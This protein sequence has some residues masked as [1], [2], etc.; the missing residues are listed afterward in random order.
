MAMDTKEI[1]EL[2]KRHTVFSWAAQGNLNPIAVDR[3]EGIYFW[4]N[5]GKRYIDFNSQLM[6]VNIGHNHPK[7]VAAIKAQADKLFFSWPGSAT[8]PRAKLGKLLSEVVPGDINKFFFT[9]GG[10]EC[11][12][13]AIKVA[14]L[15]TGRHKII[16]RYRSYHGGTH[17]A[18]QLTGDPRRW[19]T[20]PGAP[21]F[22]KVMDPAPYR[23]SFGSTDEERTRNNLAYLAEVIDYEGP[24]NIAAMF[25]EPV[26]G[27]NGI[28]APPA[29]YL[30]GLRALLDE[31]GILLVC[32]E[33]M[34]GWGRTGKLFSHEHAGITPDI[35]CMAKGL[36]SAALP[37]GAM[38]MRDKIAAYFDDNVFWAGLTYS[39]HA[40]GIAAAIAAIEVMRDEGLVE[41]AAKMQNVMRKHMTE[42]KEKHPSVATFRATGLFG[43]IDFRK[44][45]VGDPL[46]GYN[47][48]HPAVAKLVKAL[49][50]KGL[51]T[52][53]HWNYIFCNP[54][55]CISEEQLAESFAII[56]SCLEI[57]D[58][59]YED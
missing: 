51:F 24:N 55:L 27:T 38:G 33:V 22:V 47:E 49:L 28:E 13:A 23:Y 20:E 9:N 6:C 42:M 56:D 2:C 5:D 18:M 15:F 59:A 8:E 4:D 25:I 43:A 54:P 16:S 50:D 52:L 21:G 26:V 7:V 36:T 12:E 34:A 3:A 44:N 53:S 32:D 39:G 30:Q 1:V 14:R 45:A 17:G 10:A 41:H 37:L 48:T 31:H 57:T 58:E 11:N 19:A 46:S 29:G 35:I 40:M